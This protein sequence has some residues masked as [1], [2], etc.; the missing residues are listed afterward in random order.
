MIELEDN[1]DDCFNEEYCSR[2][3]GQIV[4]LG[5]PMARQ[6][7]KPVGRSSDPMKRPLKRPA[8]RAD[9]VKSSAKRPAV[10]RN[11]TQSQLLD[12]PM[13][14][15][16]LTSKPVTVGTHFSGWESVVQSLLACRI[17]NRHVFACDKDAGCRQ[18]I[19]DNFSPE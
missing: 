6:I 10:N 16:T 19:A 18:F 12:W 4:A 1:I 15:L 3:T 2:A 8:A 11:M 7:K 13:P 17:T 5:D 9:P 14:D